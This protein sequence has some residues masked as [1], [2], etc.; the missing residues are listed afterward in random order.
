VGTLG[1]AAIAARRLGTTNGAWLWL[2]QRLVPIQ[3]RRF[4]IHRS[5]LA[6]AEPPHRNPGAAYDGPSTILTFDPPNHDLDSPLGIECA[7]GRFRI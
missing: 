5:R 4:A 2:R 3:Q 1:F 6:M 7:V